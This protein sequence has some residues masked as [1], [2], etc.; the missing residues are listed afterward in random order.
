[1][2]QLIL[3]RLVTSDVAINPRLLFCRYREHRTEK[4]IVCSIWFIY[5]D[6][7]TFCSEDFS[8]KFLAL[9]H[10]STDF[11]FRKIGTGPHWTD[12]GSSFM[13]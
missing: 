6:V 3:R 13:T 1:M 12:H 10:C 5:T 4:F 7:V 2:E 9:S 11:V 8:R